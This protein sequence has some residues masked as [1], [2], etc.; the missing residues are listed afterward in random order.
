MTQGQNSSLETTSQGQNTVD[1]IAK[2]ISRRQKRK[3]VDVEKPSSGKATK[4]LAPKK[5]NSAATAPVPTETRR[6]AGAR[7]PTKSR[8]SRQLTQAGQQS[9]ASG[10]LNGDEQMQFNMLLKKANV[11]QNT[12]SLLQAKMNATNEQQDFI[13]DPDDSEQIASRERQRQQPAPVRNARSRSTNPLIATNEQQDFIDDPDA[14]DEPTHQPAHAR[15]AHSRSTKPLNSIDEVNEEDD[16]EDVGNDGGEFQFDQLDEDGDSGSDS[17]MIESNEHEDALGDATQPGL[18]NF[19]ESDD[20]Q[21]I[22][23]NLDQNNGSSTLG[24]ENHAQ[25]VNHTSTLTPAPIHNAQE[26]NADPTSLLSTKNNVEPQLAQTMVETVQRSSTVVD[27]SV[28][29][30][31]V[32]QLKGSIST[33][34]N[35]SIAQLLQE[36]RTDRDN[37][38]KLREYVSELTSVVTTAASAMFIKNP[39]SNPRIKEIQNILCLLPALFGDSFML[40]VIPRV[41]LG[42]I[43]RTIQSGSST[44]QLETK[45][46]EAY[47]VLY[48]SRKPNEKKKDK[49]DSVIGLTYSKYRYGL[50]VS[51]FLA[52]QSNAFNTFKLDTS[53]GALDPI[54][55]IEE[56]STVGPS[57][58]AMRQPFWLKRGYV[59][60]N[61]CRNAANKLEKGGHNDGRVNDGNDETQLPTDSSQTNGDAESLDIN[62]SSQSNG[63]T[64]VIRSGPLTQDEIS[65]EAAKMVYQIITSTL[66]RSRHASKVQLFHD[67]LYIFTGWAQHGVLVDQSTLKLQWEKPRDGEFDYTNDIAKTKVVRV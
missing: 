44:S 7:K 33:S 52:M 57:V 13:D 11:D 28:L 43:L 45:G 2:G 63:K 6:K 61:H 49:F 24:A 10:N 27:Y 54:N 29:L 23:I 56:S 14:A 59:L 34:V 41:V 31:I 22:S 35:A 55:T 48:F 30:N 26:K 8:S 42:F 46:I 15:S 1:A 3:V 67:V 19:G 36:I 53:N 4:R 12:L 50:L 37:I 65:T 62:D 9:T 66:Y 39:S 60:S 64:K 40:K 18:P 5:R 21:Y 16:D 51:S 25:M 32:E 38:K 20:E 17:E 58:S 47:A